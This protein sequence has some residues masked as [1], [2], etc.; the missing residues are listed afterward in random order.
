MIYKSLLKLQWNLNNIKVYLNKQKF[1]QTIINSN[2]VKKQ[3]SKSKYF[4]QK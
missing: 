4:V 3:I 1:K 2:K